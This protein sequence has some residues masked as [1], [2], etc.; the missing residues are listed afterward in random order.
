[1]ISGEQQTGPKFLGRAQ[2]LKRVSLANPAKPAHKERPLLGLRV[3]Q[4][5]LAS[6]RR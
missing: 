2:R 6:A 4:L 1:M 5:E 3:T